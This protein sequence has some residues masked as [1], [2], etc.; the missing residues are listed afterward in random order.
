LDLKEELEIG[1]LYR[2]YDINDGP[3]TQTPT[4]GGTYNK[5]Y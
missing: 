2:K 5:K 1:K 3:L 4:L